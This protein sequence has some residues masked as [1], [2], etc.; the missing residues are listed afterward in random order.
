MVRVHT[1]IGSGSDPVVWQKVASMSLD[2]VAQ[3]PD[4]HTLN[5]GGGYKVYCRSVLATE[6]YCIPMRAAV[7]CAKK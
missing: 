3:F 6:Y 1:H 7:D 2:L 4:V 5:L